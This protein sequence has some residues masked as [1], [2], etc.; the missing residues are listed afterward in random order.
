MN[1]RSQCFGSKIISV[2]PH[3][4]LVAIVASPQSRYN[5]VLNLRSFCFSYSE[6]FVFFWLYPNRYR[7]PLNIYPDD[8]K[9]KKEDRIKKISYCVLKFVL[10]AVS[11]MLFILVEELL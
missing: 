10:D 1:R 2:L 4:T 8:I 3:S 6:W 9:E 5:Q 7:N 11:C